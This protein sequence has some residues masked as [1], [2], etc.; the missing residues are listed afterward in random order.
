MTTENDSTAEPLDAADLD[1]TR[2][3]ALQDTQ[4]GFGQLWHK[5]YEVELPGVAASPEEIIQ[6]WRE[7][8]GDFWP[9]RNT[10]HA[11]LTGL[12]PGELAI[13]ELEM[14]AGTS[15]TTGVVVI[16]TTPTSFT[17]QTPEG[18]IFAAIIHFSATA[19]DS[20]PSAAIDITFR[21]SDPLF[22]LAL[23]LGGHQRED[24]F[25]SETLTNLAQV[26]GVTSPHPTLTRELLDK[27]RHWENAANVFHNGYILTQLAKLR[28]L[29]QKL[30][31]RGSPV[32]AATLDRDGT[33]AVIGAGPNG[34]AAAITLAE[35]GRDVTVYEANATPG[36]GC[37]S[38]ELTL[39][40]FVHDVCSAVH[41]LAVASPFFRD[42][43]LERWGVEWIEPPIAVAH[44]FDDGTATVLRR[45]VTETAAGLGADEEAWLSLMRPLLKDADILLPM[46]L[47]PFSAPRHPV[48]LARFGLNALQPATFFARHRF[49]DERTRALFA[50][51]AAH[52]IL[53]L[54]EPAT[55]S[56]GLVLALTGHL[57]GWPIPR[58]GSQQITGALARRLE[59]LGGRIQV[60]SRIER[61]DDVGDAE[62]VLFDTS[63]RQFL[64]ITGDTATGAYRRQLEHYRYGSAVFK[65]DW[66]LSGPVPWTAPE[67][68]EAG[69][70]H[71]GG[72]LDEIAW[73][74]A[75]V[76]KGRHPERPFVLVSQPSRFDPTRAPD[77][78]HT[79]WGYCHVPNGST[80]DMTDRIEAQIERFAPGFRDL[81][82]GR[83]TM[84]AAQMQAYNANYIGGDINAG[85]Q[86]LRQ[87][88]TRPAVR[89]DPYSTPDPRLF[90]C[91][92]STP[93]GG[94]V[95]GMGGYHA[96]KS[97][98]RRQG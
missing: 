52:S 35:A 34:L 12:K 83:S 88:F 90:F 15:L 89:F 21:T 84:G 36:G 78:Q 80:E 73:A 30:A 7:R 76:G 95:H 63:P 79:L 8:Y 38:A 50:G 14:P 28:N 59:A 56:F 65:V 24:T 49:E 86:D 44:P 40:G 20:A 27:H 6:L 51:L 39:P 46:L 82:I 87:L 1:V 11:P 97:V 81:I 2:D 43:D 32:T 4:D 29:P 64:A 75:E 74:E 96:A 55:A 94:G 92:A 53:P 91:S 5:H 17:F 42:L 9:G 77:G 45:S 19:N 57:V 37:R 72:T 31:G 23:P 25:W 18:H 26:L 98:L 10:F 67:A 62:T 58:G 71:L 48:A 66:A 13:G 22:E 61:L 16:E 70:L 3:R 69:T 54:D 33:V 93:P 47:G 85:R 60:A 41:P 68:H